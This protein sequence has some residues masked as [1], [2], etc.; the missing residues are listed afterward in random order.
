MSKGC[1][2]VGF[3]AAVAAGL[4]IGVIG[5]TAAGY[6]WVNNRVL[7]DAPREMYRDKWSKLDEAGLAGKLAPLALL[8]KQNKEGEQ[9]VALKGSEANRLFAE[10]ATRRNDDMRTSMA[11]GDTVTDITFSRRV[12]EGKYLNGEFRA[13]IKGLNGDFEVKVYSLRTGE[14]D[15]PAPLL[16]IWSRWIEGALETQALFKD[17]PLRLMDYETAKNQAKLTIKV[18]KLDKTP[19]EHSLP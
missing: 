5:L 15:W 7:A 13:D 18:V 4:I 10:Y 16:V 17:S 1:G 6:Y 11:F 3:A 2:C 19:A 8:I 14:V 12:R 9:K